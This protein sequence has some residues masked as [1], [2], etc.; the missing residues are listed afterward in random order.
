MWSPEGNTYV[1]VPDKKL[2]VVISFTSQRAVLLDFVLG[3]VSFHAFTKSILSSP[4][5]EFS[6]TTN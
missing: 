1:A 4:L 2:F 6:D 3:E 5:M